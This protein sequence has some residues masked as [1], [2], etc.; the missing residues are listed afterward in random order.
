ML[1]V[2]KG[3][4]YWQIDDESEKLCI[5]EDAPEWAKKEF[6]EFFGLV[7]PKS[8]DNGVIVCY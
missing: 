8:D 7:N 2:P 1:K 5:K 3:L 4:E 6:K